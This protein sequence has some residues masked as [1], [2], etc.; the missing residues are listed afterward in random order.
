MLRSPF[1]DDPGR[2]SDVFVTLGALAEERGTDSAG[3]ALLGGW[4]GLAGPE[5]G[6]GCRVVKGRGRFSGIWRP[7]FLPE[8]DRAP[9]ALGHTRWAT[10]GSPVEADNASP[11]VVPG[12]AA[13]PGTPSA[14]VVATHNGDVDAAGLRSRFAL[15][16]ASGATDSEPVFQLLAGCRT[17]SDITGVLESVVGR[18]ALAWVDRARPTQVHLARGALSPLTVAVDTDQNIYWASNPRWFREVER[19]TRVRF[20]SVVL[21]RE[22]TYLKVGMERRP[23][24]RDLPDVLT[25]ADFVPTARDTDL[26]PRVWTGFTAADADRDRAGLLHR[27]VEREGGT[28]GLLTVA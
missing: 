10:Q 1:A 8:L 25:T 5:A 11:M 20:A 13:F 17:T 16:P 2:A 12:T 3:L 7:E 26:D 9:V 23:G 21:L 22:G 19:H 24:R 27:V 14:G 6:G 4:P 18:V 28:G 15:P